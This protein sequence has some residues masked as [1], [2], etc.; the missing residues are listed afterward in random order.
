[1]SV[2]KMLHPFAI[3]ARTEF[4]TF[5]GG[6]GAEIIDS[7]GNRY[8]DAMASL[9]YLHAGHSCQPIIDAVT[10]QMNNLA[11]FHTFEKFSNEPAEALAAKISSLAPV[12]DSRVFFTDSGSEAVDTAMKLARASHARAGNPERRLIVSRDRGYHGVNYGGLAAM[13]LPLSKE[14]FGRML[15]DVMQVPVDDLEAMAIL[16]SERGHEIAAVISEPV[17]G[18][19]GVYPPPDGYLQGL[20]RLC[21]QY[22]AFLI[23][24]EVIT[25]FGRL[26]T[27]FAGEFYGVR[28]DMITFAKGVTSGYQPLG[29]VIIGAPVRASLE[30]DASWILRHGYTYSG[31]PTACAAALANIE[32]IGDGLMARVPHIAERLGSGLKALAADGAVDE[33][34]GVGGLW[35]VKLPGEMQSPPIRDAMMAKGV[36]PRPIGPTIA[37][38]P[39]MVITDAQIDRCVDELATAIDECSRQ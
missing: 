33:A 7:E 22:G 4:T 27:W 31:H 3:P 30:A 28:P 36:I 24:D 12:D 19:A 29:G 32:V 26:G 25:G 34:R 16:F 8:I 13:G 23:L 17:Q 18:A 20:R 39:P 11:A 10:A 1:M 38:C 6:E 15:P 21:D 35:A 14:N 5:V 9:W 2:P 37:F